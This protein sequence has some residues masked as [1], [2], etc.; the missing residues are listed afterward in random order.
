MMFS[1]WNLMWNYCCEWVYGVVPLVYAL[2]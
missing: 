2:M 1:I